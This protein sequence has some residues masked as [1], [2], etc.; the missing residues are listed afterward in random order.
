M[1]MTTLIT[2]RYDGREDNFKD[3]IYDEPHLGDAKVYVDA[4]EKMLE[5]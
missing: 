5:Y 4:I 3:W 2:C 1:R